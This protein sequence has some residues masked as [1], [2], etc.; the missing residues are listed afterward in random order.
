MREHHAPGS[1]SRGWQSQSCRSSCSSSRCSSIRR[2]CSCS[3]LALP[4]WGRCWSCPHKP[5]LRPS[6]VSCRSSK[7][8][9]TPTST[10][11]SLAVRIPPKSRGR[12]SMWE[13]VASS[14]VTTTGCI[15]K[16]SCSSTGTD[17]CWP[18][19][20]RCSS[21]RSLCRRWLF[22]GRTW[23]ARL[24]RSISV[25]A[26]ARRRSSDPRW[27]RTRMEL[28]WGSRKRSRYDRCD[29]CGDGWT[30][31]VEAVVV[32]DHACPGGSPW[33]LRPTFYEFHFR[34]LTNLGRPI[35]RPRFRI[36]RGC[37]CRR[38]RGQGLNRWGHQG[39]SSKW[40]WCWRGGTLADVLVGLVRRLS[41][42]RQPSWNGNEVGSGR[43]KIH[44]LIRLVL[45][46][47]VKRRN[48]WSSCSGGGCCSITA[49]CAVFFL[50][51]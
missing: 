23:F 44:G 5:C 51:S 42:T 40:G 49:I 41:T 1:C 32:E 48:Q 19:K 33:W 14:V 36:C 9:A 6:S 17:C 34:W 28:W 35:P 2:C 43:S 12:G 8:C 47:L 16:M 13:T 21:S 38:C 26:L 10:I 45:E 20:L 25:G 18:R 15:R 39:L 22:C 37:S 3:A 29:R 11:N 27:W 31:E 46:I 50:Q 24:G 30:A 4:S 7:T